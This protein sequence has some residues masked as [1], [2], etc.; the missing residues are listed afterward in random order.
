MYKGNNYPVVIRVIATRASWVQV[1][2]VSTSLFEFKWTPTSNHIK[3]DF[4]GKHGTKSIVNHFEY[5]NSLTQK[6]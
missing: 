3:Y 1:P 5:H 6:D 2:A 4:L